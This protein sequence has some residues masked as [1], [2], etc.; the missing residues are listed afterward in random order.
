[1][2]VEGTACNSTGEAP[3]AEFVVESQHGGAAHLLA[4]HR[5]RF[6]LMLLHLWQ[7]R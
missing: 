3:K 4:R 7:W 5:A 1:M 6:D 2:M